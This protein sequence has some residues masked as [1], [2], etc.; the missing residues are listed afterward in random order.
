MTI[1]VKRTFISLTPIFTIAALCLVPAFFLWFS[2]VFFFLTEPDLFSQ[3][4][5]NSVLTHKG[6][7]LDWSKKNFFI[8][9]E[10]HKEIKCSSLR[11]HNNG[12]ANMEL[13][14]DALLA[15]IN[16]EYVVTQSGILQP[17]IYY[18]EKALADIAVIETKQNCC[19]TE[20]FLQWVCHIPKKIWTDYKIVYHNDFAI[21]VTDKNN[22]L[23]IICSCTMPFT[24][25]LLTKCL[26][27]KKNLSVCTPHTSHA[28]TADVRFENQIIVKNNKK[29]AWCG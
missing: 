24:E 12:H 22:T 3:T 26:V 21:T 19:P 13:M 6:S 4:Y 20:K 10:N 18:T 15:K 9:L 5:T 23:C 1:R 11:K 2:S 28:F 8:Y 27:V 17:T 29:G 16:N 25:E 14:S 7:K